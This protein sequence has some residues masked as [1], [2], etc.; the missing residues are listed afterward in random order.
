[1]VQDPKTKFKDVDRLLKNFWERS[2]A[3]KKVIRKREPEIAKRLEEADRGEL[4]TAIKRFGK[5]D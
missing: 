3:A 2:S 5:G 1:M 4:D